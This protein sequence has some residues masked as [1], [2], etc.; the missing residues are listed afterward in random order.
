MRTRTWAIIII[1]VVAAVAIPL[2]LRYSAKKKASLSS[3]TEVTPAMGRIK[4]SISTTG[5]VQ[6]QNRLEIKPPIAGRIESIL[7]EEGD[8]VTKGQVLAMMSSSD[9]AALLDAAMTQGKDVLEY[10]QAVYK[11]VPLLSPIDGQ[12]IV[13]AV[14]PGQSVTAANAVIVISDHL[15]I[16]AQVDETDIGSVKTGQVARISLDAYPE[17]RS[18][19]VVDHISYESVL[20]NNVTIYKVDIFPD[21]VTDLFRSGMS[22]NVDIIRQRK[23]NVM[24]LPI[25]AVR[26]DKEGSYVLLAAAKG[27]KPERRVLEIG[28]SDGNNSEV[29]SGLSLDDRVLIETSKPVTKS[30]RPQTPQSPFMPTPPRRH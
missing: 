8:R 13:R 1:I 24:L 18:E 6:P 19:G 7:V 12:V 14:E 5:T 16:Q 29:V 25:A 2:S 23:D 21:K 15:I 3:S 30:S 10:W 26:S 9:R 22:A 20:A 17:I 4:L 11:P 27:Q 28:I